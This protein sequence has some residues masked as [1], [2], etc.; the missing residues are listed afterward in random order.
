[1]SNY[2]FTTEIK[3]KC[4]LETAQVDIPKFEITRFFFSETSLSKLTFVKI[5]ISR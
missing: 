3:A 2:A 1:M 4:Y 5:Q